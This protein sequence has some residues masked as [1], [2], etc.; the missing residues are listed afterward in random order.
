MHYS[1]NNAIP[2]CPIPPDEFACKDGICIEA[3]R[4]E[5]ALRR[6]I[7]FWLADGQ[8]YCDFCGEHCG[9]AERTRVTIER[10]R[11]FHIECADSD[12]PILA[13]FLLGS[14]CGDGA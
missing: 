1:T 3:L 13:D 14:R 8:A 11:I 2:R 6:K 10:E 5:D 4:R 7:L 12:E 9:D